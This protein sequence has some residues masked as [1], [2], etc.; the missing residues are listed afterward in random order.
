MNEITPEEEA[1]LFKGFMRSYCGYQVND[2]L[3]E[4]ASH[5]ARAKQQMPQRFAINVEQFKAYTLDPSLTFQEK[6]EE[7]LECEPATEERAVET[8]KEIWDILTE[9][10]QFPFDEHEKRIVL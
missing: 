1:E 3:E 10:A 2:S 8:W 5:V 9:N 7:M 6:V 4:V